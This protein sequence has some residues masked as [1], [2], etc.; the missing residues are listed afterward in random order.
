M[1]SLTWALQLLLGLGTCSV[2]HWFKDGVH[3]KKDF[4]INN[5]AAAS[6]QFSAESSSWFGFPRFMINDVLHISKALHSVSI[7]FVVMLHSGIPS[8]GPI[9]TAYKCSSLT[10]SCRT[11]PLSA[12]ARQTSVLICQGWRWWKGI[13]HNKSNFK[14]RDQHEM[15]VR[16]K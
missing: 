9:K 5:K 6:I 12:L 1:P 4:K 16:K 7:F 3:R 11:Y 14:I 13:N 2:L 8:I 10:H 15:W